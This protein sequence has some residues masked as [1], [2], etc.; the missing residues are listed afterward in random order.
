MKRITLVVTLLVV[1]VMA[2]QAQATKLAYVDSEVILR[3]LPEAA[4]AS[5]DLE[6]L[7]KVWQDELEK[8]GTDLQKQIEEYQK[9]EAL[10]SPQKKEEEQRRLAELQ[11]K[12]REFQ[13]T[14]FDPR[15]GEAA[16]EREKRLAPIR[17]RILKTIE[18]VAKEEGFGFV[19]DRANDVVLLYADVKFN[20]TYRVLDRLKRGTATPA[21]K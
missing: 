3:E 18:D 8:M 14:K 5:K 7:V 10:Y 6:A 11:Q 4:Q 16:T 2:L 13:Y 9:K 1:G 20:L 19:F 17:D 21:K 12:A 15:V